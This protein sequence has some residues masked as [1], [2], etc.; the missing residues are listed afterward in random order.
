MNMKNP[1]RLMAFLAQCLMAAL[2]QLWGWLVFKMGV[3]WSVLSPQLCWWDWAGSLCRSWYIS[4]SYS[5]PSLDTLL[6]CWQFLSGYFICHCLSCTF[7]F[8]PVKFSGKDLTT[9][10]LSLLLSPSWLE[11]EGVMSKER[12]LLWLRC[13]SNLLPHRPYKMMEKL[14]K[15]APGTLLPW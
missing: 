5:L 3:F 11:C 6:L 9:N 1:E 7:Y 2:P 10:V 12:S 15:E 13:G 8:L 14:D 4:D